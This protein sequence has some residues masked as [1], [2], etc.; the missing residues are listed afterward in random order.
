MLYLLSLAMDFCLKQTW[1]DGYV[2]NVGGIM[3]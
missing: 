3:S 2:F 1:M